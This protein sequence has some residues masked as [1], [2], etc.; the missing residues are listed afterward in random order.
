MKTDRLLTHYVKAATKLSVLG[1]VVTVVFFL[2]SCKNDDRRDAAKIVT[3]WMGKEILFPAD[4]PC[5]SSGS[6]TDCI[7]F[8]NQTYK[9]LLYVDSA[10]CSSC[11]LKLPEWKQIMAEADTLFA[12]TIDFLFF[13]Q[14][15]KQ[16]EETLQLIF[17]Q[18]GF[19]HPVF[20]DTENKINSI[21]RFP[22]QTDF[23]CFLLDR[24][25]KVILIGNPAFNPGVWALFKRI[26][27][28]RDT[29]ELTVE[30]REESLTDSKQTA[31]SPTFLS[32]NLIRKEYAK[33]TN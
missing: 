32:T 18:S 12:G 13:F 21:N 4:I 23:Q 22:A 20:M 14:P 19:S 9:I 24:D 7:D 2:S 26:I 11:R 15:K 16:S 3:E 6:E 29:G 30:K 25:S 5:Q 28:E 10:G 8:S 1:F 31:F 33:K 17:K 27:A